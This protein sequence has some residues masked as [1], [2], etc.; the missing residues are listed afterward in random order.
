MRCFDVFN[1]DA[2]GICALRQLR[3]AEPREA[4]L[5]TGL[6]RDIALLQRVDAGEGDLVTV[7]DVSLSRNLAALRALLG[8]GAVVR[9]FDHHDAGTVPAHPNLEAH[10]DESR[11]Q[12]T[13]ALVDRHLHGAHRAWAVAGA[14]GDN[15]APTA[16]ALARLAGLDEE[17]VA[18]LQQLG[19]C[20]NYNAYGERDDVMFDPADLYRLAA[21]HADALRFAQTPQITR[22]A[23]QREKDLDL[24]RAVPALRAAAS[25]SAYLLP[26]AGWSRRVG[27]TF[28]NELA[29][30][31][32]RC[33]HAVL[34]RSGD[35]FT[36]SI[37]APEGG[38]SAA[39]FC[40]RHAGGGGR[41]A[42][43]GIE[44][45]APHELEAF[46]ERFAAQW[47]AVT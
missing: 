40:A 47:S 42:A 25:A 22:L 26:D 45:L 44:R 13:S 35:A 43:G 32:P 3:L 38:P 14:F 41:V 2:D 17:A 37:R 4:T 20:L 30:R 33:A 19:E 18:R 39:A 5:V 10:I 21:A 31:Q 23:A 28:A 7:L 46:L 34:W 15:L 16:L 9:Y 36:V 1:G 29:A 8:R 24:A 11:A 12:C 6:K 27:G